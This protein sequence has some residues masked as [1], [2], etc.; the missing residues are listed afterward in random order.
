M[1]TGESRGPVVLAD[2]MYPIL[3]LTMVIQALEEKLERVMRM[4]ATIVKNQKAILEKKDYM[5][6]RTL[7]APLFIR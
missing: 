4:Q 5:Q 3:S 7:L 6:V 2:C 1:R